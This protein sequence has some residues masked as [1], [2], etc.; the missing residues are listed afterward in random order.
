L[1]PGYRRRR[2]LGGGSKGLMICH[3]S[4]SKMGFATS[5]PPCTS[6]EC[7]L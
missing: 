3:N 7:N 2:R 4:S 1:R 6:E 5:V